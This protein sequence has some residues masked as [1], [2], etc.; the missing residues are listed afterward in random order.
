MLI[1][2]ILEV[3]KVNE[4]ELA[5]K[6]GALIDSFETGKDENDIERELEEIFKDNDSH[7]ILKLIFKLLFKIKCEVKE[8]EEKL[9]KIFRV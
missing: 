7:Y 8:I 4:Q 2:K 3:K 1:R 6:I 9:D 5:Q